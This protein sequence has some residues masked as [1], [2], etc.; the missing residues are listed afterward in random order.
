MSHRQTVLLYTPD[1]LCINDQE[2]NTYSTQH[3]H[4][5]AYVSNTLHV[6]NSP[7]IRR[8]CFSKQTEL[9]WLSRIMICLSFTKVVVGN[10]SLHSTY[11]LSANALP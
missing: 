3:I 10:S 1:L 11:V 8:C 2:F 5:A 9:N 6:I 7:L 4:V